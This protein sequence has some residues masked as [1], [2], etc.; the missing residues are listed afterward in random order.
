MADSEI[1]L[2][3]V[4]RQLRK[5]LMTT[6][7]A[8]RGEDLRFE[9]QDLE[10]ELQVVVSKGG[11]GELSGEGGV[12]LWVLAKAGGTATGSYESSRI[13]K[14]KLRLKPKLGRDRARAGERDDGPVMLTAD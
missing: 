13:Q 3:D 12:K 11:S 5:E 2:A 10:I 6:A 14:V 1:P 9:V 8:G 7:R 4:V